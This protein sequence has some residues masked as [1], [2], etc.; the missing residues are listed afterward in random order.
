M[1]SERSGVAEIEARAEH[2]APD[3]PA[4]RAGL[5]AWVATFDRSLLL[6]ALLLTVVALAYFWTPTDPDVWWHLRNG[7]VVATT[8]AV[9]RG[10]IYSF[11]V[12]GARWIMQQWLLETAMYGIEQTLGYWANVLLFAGVS[13]A[14]YAM[15]FA[16]LRGEGAARP[17]AVGAVLGALVLDAPS[18]GVRPQIWTTLFFTIFLALL[19]RY[20][21][22]GRADPWFWLLPGLMLLWANIHAGFSAGLLLLGAFLVGETARRLLGGSGAPLRP[23]LAVTVLSAAASLIN[24]N[25]LDLWLYPLTY[26]GGPGGNASLRF[27]QEWQPPDFRSVRSWPFA[28][29]LISLLVLNLVRGMGK[30]GAGPADPPPAAAPARPWADFSLMLALAGVT[31]MALQALRFAPLFGLLWAV[32][33]AG[34]LSE[35]WPQREPGTERPDASRAAAGRR[36]LFGRLNVGVY[37][38]S[39]LL[40]AGVMLTN[41]RAQVHAAPLERDYPAGA[42]AYLAD[43]AA[44]LPRPLHLFHEY[45]WGGYL[46]AKGL[47]VFVDGRADPYNTLLD[48]Y[49]AARAGVR[50][51]TIF[52][53]HQVNAVLIGPGGPLDAA[54]AADPGWTRAYHDAGAVLYIKQ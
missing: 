29:A 11:T 26:L 14:V 45:G 22:L 48:D 16:I 36:A 34:R 25:G 27:V 2:V 17:V 4:R 53:A 30:P 3:R 8:G 32:V 40:L 5:G 12:P 10:D 52:A 20:R 31:L 9:P 15:L 41:P 18:W 28:A 23:L 21:R 1:S 19:L 42:V 13:V 39:A 6:L 46:I 7:Q 38:L 33:F 24:P 54:L 50:W 35:L 44:A 43:H 47:P 37:A 49:V 51:A